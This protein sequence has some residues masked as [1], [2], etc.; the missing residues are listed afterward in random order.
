VLRSELL[1]I[2]GVGPRTVEKL[3]QHFGSARRVRE[4]DLEALAAV[5]GRARAERIRQHFDTA[6]TAS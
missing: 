4:A 6:S 3:L 1:D 2:P 5:V